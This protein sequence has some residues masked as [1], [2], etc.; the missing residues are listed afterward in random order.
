MNNAKPTLPATRQAGDTGAFP[1]DV[2]SELSIVIRF[3]A[4]KMV[5]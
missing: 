1:A 2:S 5:N 4:K 3:A